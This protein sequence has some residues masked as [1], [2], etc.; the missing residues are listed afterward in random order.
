MLQ[1]AATWCIAEDSEVDLA[2]ISKTPSVSFLKRNVICFNWIIFCSCYD[3]GCTVHGKC[4]S[5]HCIRKF[6]DM[7]EKA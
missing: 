6:V 1:P 4:P 5:A 7:N 3:D 2:E